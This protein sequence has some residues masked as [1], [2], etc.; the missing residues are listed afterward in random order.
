[1]KNEE[2]IVF[3]EMLCE[4][5]E[6]RK[7]SD[8]HDIDNYKGKIPDFLIEIWKRYGLTSHGEG[9]IWFVDPSEFTTIIKGFFGENVGFIAYARHSFG[10]IYAILEDKLYI[11]HPQMARAQYMGNL[12]TLPAQIL[13]ILDSGPAH[14]QHLAALKKFGPINSS[15]MYGYVPVLAL[16]GDGSLDET[17]IVQMHEYL[18][19]TA[20]IATEAVRNG[21][22]PL[23][24]PDL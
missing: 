12:D 9:E 1:M 21:W 18:L 2:K 24:L 23:G 10:Y 4:E 14:K 7:Y 3:F 13:N 16:G 17:Q 6:Y 15:Q 11:I 5:N 19:M 20:E 8:I 22:N